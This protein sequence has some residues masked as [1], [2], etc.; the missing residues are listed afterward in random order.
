M[1]NFFKLLSGEPKNGDIIQCI[2]LSIVI[3]QLIITLLIW[4]T[5]YEVNSM[6]LGLLGLL[7]AWQIGWGM[8]ITRFI[9]HDKNNRL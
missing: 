1:K 9:K 3:P 5:S 2:K 4:Y 8:S 6:L 7:F